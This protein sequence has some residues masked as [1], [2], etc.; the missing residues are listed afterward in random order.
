MISVIIP[1]YNVE[2]YITNCLKSFEEQ[3]YRD[4]E[5]IIVNDGSTD[6]SVSIVQKFIEK[7]EL[8]IKLVNQKNSGVSVARNNGLNNATGDY[9]CFVDSDDMVAPE[10]LSQ[11]VEIIN[12]KKCDMV[13]CGVKAID[14]G[15]SKSKYF[16]EEYTSEK[17]SSYE[18]LRR[19]LYSEIVSGVWSLMIK[20]NIID[21]NQLRFAE[22]YRYSEDLELVWKMLIH[23]KNVAI[24]GSELY[25]YRVRNGSAMSVVDDKRIDGFKL[26]KGLESY[27]KDN[28]PDFYMEFKKYGTARWIWSTLWQIAVASQNFKTFQKLAVEIQARSYMRK[29]LT[30]KIKKVS[31]SSLL[32]II[33]PRFYYYLAQNKG[34]KRFKN[35][36]VIKIS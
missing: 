1:L 31:F 15:S 29:L 19:F 11:M 5:V 36:E 24:T 2:D 18:A 14:E 10:Y 17:M 21:E 8:N 30:F 20:R 34:K 32:Y 35:R 26:M 9:I 23:S 22:G 33:C 4:F 12:Y 16:F 6:K 3:I 25:L 28:R 7:S 27:F 13:I